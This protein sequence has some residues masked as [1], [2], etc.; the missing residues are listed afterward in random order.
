MSSNGK[1]QIE[2]EFKIYHEINSKHG[3]QES[4]KTIMRQEMKRRKE[5]RKTITKNAQKIIFKIRK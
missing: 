2:V 5:K 3:N 4:N 1:R